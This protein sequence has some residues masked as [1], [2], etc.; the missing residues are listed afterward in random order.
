MGQTGGNEQALRK[1]IEFT[2]MGSIII[3]TFHCYYSCH[4]VVRTWKL[5]ISF[6]DGIFTSLVRTGLFDSIYITKGIS[7]CLLAV[8][9]IGV[10]G[11][12]SDEASLSACATLV[13]LGLTMF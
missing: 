7:L 10:K 13:M 6:I 11:K 8:S 5:S 1:I 12:K 3:L 4:G 2:R 9:L